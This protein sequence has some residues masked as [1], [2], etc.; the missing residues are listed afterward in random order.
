[1]RTWQ[2]TQSQSCPTSGFAR[3]DLKRG[4]REAKAAHKEKIENHFSDN[5][6][7]QVW[8]GIQSITNY[9][10]QA[11]TPGSSDRSLAEELNSFFA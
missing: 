2:H 6:P 9:R 3:A 11:V 4:I 1:M 5:N 8:Q 10:G 7:R